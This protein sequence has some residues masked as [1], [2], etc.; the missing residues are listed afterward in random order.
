MVLNTG[1]GLRIHHKNL[2]VERNSEF[3]K[4]IKESMHV[5]AIKIKTIKLFGGILTVFS[6]QNY[7]LRTLSPKPILCNIWRTI[8]W[9]NLQINICGILGT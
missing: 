9:R 8:C 3:K 4:Y 5:Y 2:F 7:K 6:K 1:K